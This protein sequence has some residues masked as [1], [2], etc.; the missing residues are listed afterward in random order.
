MQ[1]KIRPPDPLLLKDHM[2]KLRKALNLS[3]NDLA[4]MLDVNER[5]IRRW[6][7]G[8]VPTP[9][10]V[11]MLLEIWANPEKPAFSEH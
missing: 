8:E 9:K 6:E 7:H 5:T 11:L 3:I 4:A 2:K 1:V 10:A